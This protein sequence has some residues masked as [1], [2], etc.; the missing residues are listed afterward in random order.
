MTRIEKEVVIRALSE[1]KSKYKRKAKRERDREEYKKGA[2]S[3][4]ESLIAGS[5]MMDFCTILEEPC[6]SVKI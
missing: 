4:A 1:Y 6:G 2:S 5:V 3:E